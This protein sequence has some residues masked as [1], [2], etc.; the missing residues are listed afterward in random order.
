VEKENAENHT[1]PHAIL[2]IQVL[3]VQ[4]LVT[5]YQS[6]GVVE[7]KLQNRSIVLQKGR[8]KNQEN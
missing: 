2:D 5:L 3:F 4:L 7:V 6:E 1:S 8:R